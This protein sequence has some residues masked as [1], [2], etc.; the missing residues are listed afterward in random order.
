MNFIVLIG[1]I[2]ITYEI[3]NSLTRHYQAF[4]YSLSTIQQKNFNLMAEIYNNFHL[5]VNLFCYI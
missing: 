1:L 4:V 2:S 5:R 3:A